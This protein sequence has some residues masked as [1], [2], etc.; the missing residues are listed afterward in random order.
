MYPACLWSQAPGHNGVRASPF[1]KVGRTPKGSHSHADLGNAG[2][3]RSPTHLIRL[4]NPENDNDRRSRRVG[5]V[6]KSV[7]L[8]F[9]R[10]GFSKPDL[11]TAAIAGAQYR[12][13][14]LRIAHAVRAILF[15]KATTVTLR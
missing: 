15:A 6:G 4:A 7:L 5:K 2:C 3:D 8:T 1:Y 9:P 12:V 10:S 11:Y 14:L 13:P